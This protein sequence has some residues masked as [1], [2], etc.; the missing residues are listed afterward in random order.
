[1]EMEMKTAVTAA[2]TAALAEAAAAAVTAEAAAAAQRE[3]E[4][5]GP[6]LHALALCLRLTCISSQMQVRGSPRVQRPR[7]ECC[8]LPLPLPLTR[9]WHFGFVTFHATHWRT[10]THPRRPRCAQLHSRIPRGCQLVIRC[11]SHESRVQS[12]NCFLSYS[13][14]GDFQR[15]DI[16]KTQCKNEMLIMHS[17]K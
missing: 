11:H 3:R 13:D 12:R 6:K 7:S 2:A 14:C 17:K 1:M 10:L 5:G 4:R 16:H 15:W 9:H 8:H